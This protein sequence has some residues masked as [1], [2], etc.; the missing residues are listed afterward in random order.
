MYNYQNRRD[1]QVFY[2][3][4]TEMEPYL[5][6][7][8]A[9]QLFLQLRQEGSSFNHAYTEAHKDHETRLT[10]IRARTNPV[11]DAVTPLQKYLQA[12]TTEAL[13]LIW[14]ARPKTATDD[15]MRN[16]WYD[17]SSGVTQY[18]YFAAV[19]WELSWRKLFV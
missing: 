17:R 7:Y 3:P 13:E 12:V 10:A 18:D 5:P 4:D 1:D 19:E 9:Y 16:V 11:Q 2:P 8:A 14:S 6:D 15:D